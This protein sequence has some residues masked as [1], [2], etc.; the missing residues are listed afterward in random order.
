MFGKSS[1]GK[2]DELEPSLDKRGDGRDGQTLGNGMLLNEWF[3]AVQ[4]AGRALDGLNLQ[5]GWDSS[6]LI[7]GKQNPILDLPTPT[8]RLNGL[9][10]SGLA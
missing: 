9:N 1:N 7:C 2:R 6:I 4:S 10:A 8:L 5:P 3:R